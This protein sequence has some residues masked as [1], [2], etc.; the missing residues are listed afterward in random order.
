MK[1]SKYSFLITNLLLV[2]FLFTNAGSV[3][4]KENHAAVCHDSPGTAR[5]HSH[6]VVD[7]EGKPN[8]VSTPSGYGPLQFHNAY[9]VGTN[10]STYQVIAIVDAYD[11][12]NILSDLNTYSNAFGIPALPACSGPVTSS[13]VPCFQKV[14][15]Y[16]GASY[17]AI[18]AGWALEIALDVEAAHAMCQ[19]CGILLVEASSNSFANLM[20]AVDTAVAMGANVISNSYGASEFSSETSYDSHFN[21]PGTAITFSSGDSGYGAEYPA[22]SQYVTA[23]GGTSLYLNPDS[24]YKSESAWSGAGSGCSAFEPK[25]IWQTDS[26]CANRTISDVSAD[27]DPATGAAVYDSVRYQGKKGWFKVGGTS[28]SAPLIAGIYALAGGISL[29]VYGASLP[30]SLSTPSNLH[31]IAIGSN[32][33]CAGSYLCTSLSGYDGPTGLGTPNGIAAF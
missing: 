12:P 21:H 11:H 17:P 29:G 28:L 8:A 5:C 7:K 31:D 1:T 15:P 13:P 19:N 33:S 16:G 26:G 10:S 32:G 30:Y 14:N 4:A 3:F 22:A 18:N 2:S 20:Q 25:P 24:S 6:V 23:V 27:A 9:A